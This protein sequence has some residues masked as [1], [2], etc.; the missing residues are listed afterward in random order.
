MYLH[1]VL[2]VM[3]YSTGLKTPIS[4]FEA[5]ENYKVNKYLIASMIFHGPQKLPYF[6]TLA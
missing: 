2:Q 6:S 1:L 5:G 3:P 4:N